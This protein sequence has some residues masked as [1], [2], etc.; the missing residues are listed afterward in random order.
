MDDVLRPYHHTAPVAGRMTTFA[1]MEFPKER[2]PRE[3]VIGENRWVLQPR[4]YERRDDGRGTIGQAIG[5]T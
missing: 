4:E 3:I 2:P 1:T 5:G